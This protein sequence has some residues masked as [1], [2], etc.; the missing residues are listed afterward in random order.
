MRTLRFSIPFLQDYNQYLSDIAPED[1]R[2]VFMKMCTRLR[3]RLGDIEFQQQEMQYLAVEVGDSLPKFL[4][5][6][7]S[8]T[9]FKEYNNSR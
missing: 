1:L 7:F 8:P 2:A 3:S 4:L 6:N 9:S 5:L